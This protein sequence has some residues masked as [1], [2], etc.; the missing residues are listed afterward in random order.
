[1]LEHQEFQSEGDPPDTSG[2]ES[3]YEGSKAPP[4]LP[5]RN[6][7]PQPPPP[8]EAGN[9]PAAKG[10][11]WR[12]NIKLGVECIGLVALIVYTVFSV[13]QWAQIRWTNRLTREAL[14]GSNSTLSQTLTK[15]QAQTD[16][17]NRLYQEAQKQTASAATMAKNSGIQA[18]AN[19]RSADA[20]KSAADTAKETLLVSE[21]AYI[22]LEGPTLDFAAKAM[23]LP[24]VNSGRLPS[25]P[26]TTIV[27][28]AT[29]VSTSDRVFDRDVVDKSWEHTDWNSIPPGLS[30]NAVS[31]PFPL[32]DGKELNSGQQMVIV[33]GSLSYNDG[34]TN[35]PRQTWQFCFRTVHHLIMNKSIIIVCDPTHFLPALERIDGYPN[36][37]HKDAP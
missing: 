2:Q 36:N 27:H 21:R 16:A 5:P 20:A 6:S 17:T 25:G 23:N 34:F 3:A 30:T 31:I 35:T 18:K 1:M 32:L 7:P 24:I 28:S 29:F 4:S 13:L 9:N 19:G 33:A 22:R 12:N 37:E 8:P 10:S 26:M 15:M 14:D 11:D